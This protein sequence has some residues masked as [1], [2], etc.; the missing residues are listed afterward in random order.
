[1]DTH[2]LV[3]VDH[4]IFWTDPKGNHPAPFTIITVEDVEKGRWSPA[5][6]SLRDRMRGYV[7]A[8]DA[9]GRYPL[10]IWPPHCLIGS[11]GHN[12]FE[13][14]RKALLE[15]EERYA[16]VE[17][18][19]KGTSP[20]TEHYSAVQADVPDDSDPS[21][22]PNRRLIE[23]VKGA[24]TVVVAGE[25]SSHCL[26]NTV[27]DLAVHLGEEGVPLAGQFLVGYEHL[28]H[29]DKRPHNGD[30]HLYG[31]LAVQDTGKHCDALLSEN[32]GQVSP[33]AP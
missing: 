29:P 3:D 24:D 28:P 15:W 5:D 26:A 11:W 2:H 8:L 6:P 13:P 33:A 1:M 7:R 19:V 32:V 31:L 25:A 20:Y 16:M 17:Y 23:A 10:C 14:L 9:S 21:T 18:V 30:I 22:L 12:V 27:R 4:P